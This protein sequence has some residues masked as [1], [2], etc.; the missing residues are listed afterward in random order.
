MVGGGQAGLG[1]AARLTQ[2]GVDTLIVDRE[3][4]VGDNW[5]KRYHALVLHNQVHVNH[6][7]IFRFRR[8][9]RPTYRRTSSPIGSKPMPTSW[10]LISGQTEFTGATYDETEQRWSA[11]LTKPDGNKRQIRPQHIVMATSVSGIPKMPAIP[12][13]ENFDGEVMHSGKYTSAAGRQAAA[14]Y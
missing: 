1:T 11:E 13:L 3:A 4:R 6:L 8:T 7:P 2:L 12:T 14:M 10:S 9:G 5:R